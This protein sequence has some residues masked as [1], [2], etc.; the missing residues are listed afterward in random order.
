MINEISRH[1]KTNLNNYSEDDG[2]LLNNKLYQINKENFFP[3]NTSQSEKS[4]AFIDGGQAQILSAGNFSLGFIRVAGVIFKDNKK[5]KDYFAEF[6]IYTTAKY[7]NNDLIYES[8]VFSEKELFI[9]TDDLTISSNDEAIKTGPERAPISKVLGMARRFTE[10][11]LAAKIDADYILLDGTLEPTYPNEEKYL[12][13]LAGNVSALAKSSN[14][15]TTSGNSPS[16]LLN[17]MGPLGCWKYQIEKNN[18]FVKLNERAKHIFRFGGNC[19][20]LLHLIENSKDAIFLGYPYGLI[21]ADKLARV[22]N[23]EKHSL[24]MRF[25]LQKENKIITDYLSTTN[26]H[27]ILDSLG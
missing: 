16:I 12:E 13:K 6:F 27:D 21:V 20:I 7:Y 23:S 22:S 5:F 3:I 10:L 14:L 17:R 4:I 9:N 15:F 11:A 1:I 24:K 18:S 2:L 19:E 26:A 8:K 25:L